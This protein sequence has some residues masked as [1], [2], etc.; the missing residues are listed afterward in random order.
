MTEPVKF[1]YTDYVAPVTIGAYPAGWCDPAM[2]ASPPYNS[3]TYLRADTAVSNKRARDMMRLMFIAGATSTPPF[4]ET[5]ERV[6]SA[7]NEKLDEIWNR[8]A[9]D[10]NNVR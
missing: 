4:D 10:S 3:L 5:K 9:T 7:I 2:G 6:E 8:Y 1:P